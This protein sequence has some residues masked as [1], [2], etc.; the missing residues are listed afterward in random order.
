M[1]REKDVY[2]SRDARAPRR[3]TGLGDGGAGGR[4]VTCMV[5]GLGSRVFLDC[6]G[7]LGDSLG[8]NEDCRHNFRA[9][10]VLC[11]MTGIVLIAPAVLYFMATDNLA[12]FHGIGTIAH[13]AVDPLHL[14]VRVVLATSVGRHQ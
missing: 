8:P 11:P 2:Q 13:L 5:E 6:F 4:P 9:Q 12:L 3:G 7:L 10:D 1:R 14:Q